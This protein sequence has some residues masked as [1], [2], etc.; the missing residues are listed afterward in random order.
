MHGAL[1][2]SDA[3]GVGRIFEAEGRKPKR[4]RSETQG[5]ADAD[6]SLKPGLG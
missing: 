1:R 5:D 2:V 3:L 4:S 6:E